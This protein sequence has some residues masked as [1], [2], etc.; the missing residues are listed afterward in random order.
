MRSIAERLQ[1]DYYKD[2]PMLSNGYDHMLTSKEFDGLT[3]RPVRN[4]KIFSD[5]GSVAIKDP[6]RDEHC[7]VEWT[8]DVKER[9][10]AIRENYDLIIGEANSEIIG[11]ASDISQ[12][13]L[14]RR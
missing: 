6:S 2:A 12:R 9:N 8:V 13:D 7:I 4:D 11:E 3:R 10:E 1:K 14:P 5:D